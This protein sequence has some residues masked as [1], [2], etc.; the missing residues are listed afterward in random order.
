MQ[1]RCETI[2]LLHLN[3]HRNEMLTFYWLL[4]YMYGLP[5]FFQIQPV[6]CS[7]IIISITSLCISS[8]AIYDKH[9]WNL[10]H[11]IKDQISV[12]IY[13]GIYGS[14][15]CALYTTIL[16]ID[17]NINVTYNHYVVSISCNHILKMIPPILLQCH[18]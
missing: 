2:V 15:N 7:V 13:C 10:W 14:L 6:Y 18:H 3:D 9:L 5:G 4:L 16:N 8:F 12:G 17:E 1:E 11:A